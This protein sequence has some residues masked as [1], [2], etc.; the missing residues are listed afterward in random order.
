MEIC[1]H[2][3]RFTEGNLNTSGVSEG[4]SYLQFLF[5]NFVYVGVPG[6]QFGRWTVKFKIFLKR[7]SLK[8]IRTF[9]KPQRTSCPPKNRSNLILRP[10]WDWN[11]DKLLFCSKFLV[12]HFHHRRGK[13]FKFYSSFPAAMKNLLSDAG[14][15]FKMHGNFLVYRL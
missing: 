9:F 1:V 7:C 4:K 15:K 8:Y 2:W 10:P 6:S 3:L 14:R 12:R 5:L 13:L 11:S